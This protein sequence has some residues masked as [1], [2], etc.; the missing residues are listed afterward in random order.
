M[1]LILLVLSFLWG[2]SP[3][4]LPVIWSVRVAGGRYMF[5]P[6]LQMDWALHTPPTSFDAL[7]EVAERPCGGVDQ[8]AGPSSF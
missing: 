3:S 2:D 5:L 7:K 6:P 1:D 8:K 4:F